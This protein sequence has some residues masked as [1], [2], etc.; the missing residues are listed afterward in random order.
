MSRKS[1]SKSKHQNY[2]YPYVKKS[3]EIRR[4]WNKLLK[5]I[6]QLIIHI[7]YTYSSYISAKTGCI[8]NQHLK[9]D[10]GHRMTNGRP[11]FQIIMPHISKPAAGN[12]TS[13]YF[14]GIGGSSAK[15]K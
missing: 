6:K 14:F 4:H 10:V 11:R 5:H 13:F 15:A 1:I 7:N 3:R 12:L 8:E 2:P 9:E